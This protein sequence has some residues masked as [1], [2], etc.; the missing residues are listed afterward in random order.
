[1]RLNQKRKSTAA[2]A[3]G[4]GPYMS[5]RS[6]HGIIRHQNLLNASLLLQPVLRVAARIGV[7]ALRA[8][9]C[10]HGVP[11]FGDFVVFLLFAVS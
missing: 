10:T 7:L 1:M 5:P 9:P 2:L 3:S 8:L 6:A 11:L 4:M